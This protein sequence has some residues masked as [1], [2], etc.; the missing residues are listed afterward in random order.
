MTYEGGRMRGFAYRG[1]DGC[2]LRAER[3]KMRAERRRE[4]A[5]QKKGAER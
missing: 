2:R 5:Q 3:A 4:R 1:S